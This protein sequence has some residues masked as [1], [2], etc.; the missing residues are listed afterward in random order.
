MVSDELITKDPSRH[1]RILG[2]CWAIY[3]VVHLVAAVWMASFSNT[4]TVMFGAMLVRVAD[5]FTM[6]SFFHLIYALVLALSVA[7]AVLGLLAGWA[8]L[9]GQRSGRTLALV[10]GFLSVSNIPLGTTLGIYSLVVLLPL[11]ARHA[12]SAVL[13][14]RASDL[15]G[16]PSAT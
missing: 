11:S 1:L 14:N 3:A 2:I 16:Q 9:P 5:P 8:L 7:R 6:M 15:R 10:A 4:A 13:G 12:S